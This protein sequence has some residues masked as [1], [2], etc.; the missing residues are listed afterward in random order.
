[1]IIQYQH[2]K[3]L[4]MLALGDIGQYYFIMDF[5]PINN[6]GWTIKSYTLR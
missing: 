1:M 5:K 3:G 2:H 4:V 6:P